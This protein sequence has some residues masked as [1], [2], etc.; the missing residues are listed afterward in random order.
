[1]WK[2][3]GIA[4]IALII[5]GAVEVSEVKAQYSY[6][7]PRDLRL[8]PDDY[9]MMKQAGRVGMDGKPEGTVIPWSNTKS[10]N[11]GTVTLLKR[12]E[13][14]GQE[15][16]KILHTISGRNL[17]EPAKYMVTLCRQPDGS[18]KSPAK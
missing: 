4:I 2:A 1:M 9:N 5:G 8:T 14:K 3:I 10:G 6:T 16:R 12:T 11:A 18:W 13:V 15:C 17:A 7:F